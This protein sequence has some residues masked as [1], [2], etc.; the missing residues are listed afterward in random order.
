MKTYDLD[1]EV[2]RLTGELLA[3]LDGWRGA[4]RDFAELTRAYTDS[5]RYAD[6]SVTAV[7]KARNDPR[8]QD[9]GRYADWYQREIMA[10][11]TAILALRG[12]S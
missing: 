9:A 2:D 6:D 7:E 4:K 11:A 5:P 3:A 8:R 1:A 10:A 12:S